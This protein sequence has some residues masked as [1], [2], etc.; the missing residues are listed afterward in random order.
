MYG[1][2]HNLRLLENTYLQDT[3]LIICSMEGRYNYPEIDTLMVEPEF[4]D[5]I[6]RLIITA[7][8]SCFARFALANQEVFS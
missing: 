8:Q 5:V 6:D 2:S 7:E 4:E 1:A 3:K